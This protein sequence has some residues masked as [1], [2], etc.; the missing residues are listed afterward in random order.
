MI[1]DWYA[2]HYL[3]FESVQCNNSWCSVKLWHNSKIPLFA[4]RGVTGIFFKGGKVIFLDF[5]PNLKCFFR[6]ENS[7]FGRPKTNF[8]GFEKWKAKKKK[9]KKNKSSP[10]FVTFP[11]SIFNFPPFLFW[12][13]FFPSPF[14]FVSLPLFSQYVSR[15][16]PVRSI[17]GGTLPPAPR[18]LRHCLLGCL[19]TKGDLCEGRGPF[20]DPPFSG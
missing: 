11:P 20:H 12:F 5:F 17:W 8:S 9:K 19:F 10:H 15:N 1:W 2:I 18:L 3:C 4:S 6:V 14:S 7:H 16:F 13:S